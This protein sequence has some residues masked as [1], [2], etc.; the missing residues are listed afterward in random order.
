MEISSL[1]FIVALI[2]PLLSAIQLAV[3]QCSKISKWI[4]RCILAAVSFYIL[5]MGTVQ[6]ASGEADRHLAT[7][8]LNGDGYFSG[9]ELTPEAEQALSD[10]ASDTGMALAPITGLIFAPI[11][12]GFWHFLIGVPSLWIIRKQLKNQSEQ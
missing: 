5:L 2:L 9:E 10:W 1:L 12:S 4:I 7:F 6:L 3:T 8:D 11:Y